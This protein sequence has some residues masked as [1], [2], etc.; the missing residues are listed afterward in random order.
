MRKNLCGPTSFLR[1]LAISSST[2]DLK[3]FLCDLILH[4]SL[5]L[6][7]SFQKILT[8][9]FNSKMSAKEKID[10]Y[11]ESLKLLIA[12]LRCVKEWQECLL[13]VHSNKAVFDN[14]DPSSIK[15]IFYFN[16]QLKTYIDK[17]IIIYL[18]KIN[19]KK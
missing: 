18:I 1:S 19:L 10:R 12:S 5:P 13:L 7:V 4:T 9:I 11:N 17:V 2:E 8:Q 6:C 15:V 3:S 16:I 14:S